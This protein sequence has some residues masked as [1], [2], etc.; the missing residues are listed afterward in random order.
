MIMYSQDVMDP[1]TNHHLLQL[2]Y[3]YICLIT[4]CPKGVGCSVEWVVAVDTRNF[5][6]IGLY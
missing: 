6:K 4:G 2:P 3:Y 1:E 5:L